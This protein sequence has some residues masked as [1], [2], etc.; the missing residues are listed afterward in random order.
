MYPPTPR[1]HSPVGMGV[2]ALFL[3]PSRGFGHSFE[4]MGLGVNLSLL[5]CSQK[6]E[7]N[8]N[9]ILSSCKLGLTYRFQPQRGFDICLKVSNICLD[10]REQREGLE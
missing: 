2:V 8:C 4:T 9:R 7:I 10:T 3:S 6:N 5:Y 1:P